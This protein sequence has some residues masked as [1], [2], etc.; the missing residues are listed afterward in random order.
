MDYTP[1]EDSDGRYP[2]RWA[3]MIG[4]RALLRLTSL[5]V[6]AATMSAPGPSGSH[7]DFEK[8]RNKAMTAYRAGRWQEAKQHWEQAH[9]IAPDAFQPIEGLAEAAAQLWRPDEAFAW[10]AKAYDGGVM[11]P[12]YL[13]EDEDYRSLHGDARWEPLLAALTTDWDNTSARLRQRQTDPDPQSAP[14]FKSYRKLAAAFNRQRRDLDDDRWYLSIAQYADGTSTIREQR[15]AALHRYLAE[16][17]KAGDRADAAWDAVGTRASTLYI[18]YLYRRWGEFGTQ[19]LDEID[20]FLREF[21]GSP[22]C[23]QASLDRAFVAFGVRPEGGTA[24]HPWRDED[25]LTL[26]RSL[27]EISRKFA[28]TTAGGLALAWRLMLADDPAIHA[29]AP[30]MS[31]MKAQL[32]EQYGHDR[33]VLKILWG[34]PGAA[35]VLI[36]GIADF[37][38]TDLAGT[39]WT[40]STFKGKVTLIDFWATWCGPC[41]GEIPT[42]RKAWTAYHDKGL[43][44]LGVSLDFDD[45]AQF[46]GWL[47]RNDVAWPQIWDGK[48]FSTPLARKYG[49]HGIP[50]TVLVDRD[51][52]VANVGLRGDALLA[53]IRVL[54]EVRGEL[55]SEKPASIQ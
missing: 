13:R 18:Y 30:E 8:L 31:A 20:H 46:E 9:A 4:P 44:V 19:V 16:H 47:A 50:F 14:S 39:R 55:P 17:P 21:P 3:E 26:D 11:D 45:R 23:G 33:E 22:H 32:D 28:G 1:E 52:H 49:V 40:A 25:M 38:G 42:I 27:S 15:I 35:R 53:R 37:D 7:R 10:L 48:G 41:V 36:S 5:V 6:F 24:D 51:G 12:A 43:A 54:L 34:Y 29:G 2:R